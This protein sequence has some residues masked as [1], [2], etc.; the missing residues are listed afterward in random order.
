MS[1]CLCP[2]GAGSDIW[3]DRDVCPPP[4]GVMHTRCATCGEAL[5]E[6]VD[7]IAEV[8][9]DEFIASNV[10]DDSEYVGGYAYPLDEWGTRDIDPELIALIR[11]WQNQAL[12]RPDEVH[13]AWSKA[14][15]RAR[16]AARDRDA[17]RAQMKGEQ[18]AAADYRMRINKALGSTWGDMLSPDATVA[19]IE[20]LHGLIEKAESDKEKLN[21]QSDR[22]QR[23]LAQ[24]LGLAPDLAAWTAWGVLRN[25]LDELDRL[26]KHLTKVEDDKI[27]LSGE[28]ARQREEIERLRTDRDSRSG[29]PSRFGSRGFP[30]RVTLQV[31]RVKCAE[32]DEDP[33][34]GTEEVTM[35]WA[36]E[37][38]Y[39]AG[40][41]EFT[42]TPMNQYVE[43]RYLGDFKGKPQYWLLPGMD[44]ETPS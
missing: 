4:C 6:C 27:A 34:W 15:E 8:S 2:G 23:R 24:M 26:R 36:N 28:N 42:V 10:S 11:Y 3:F 17:I 39:F 32:C 20:R 25:R 5:D 12:G 44:E 21:D 19:E 18:R 40:H 13:A 41:T 30:P 35:P 33:V 16:D 1:D 7:R 31:Q 43:Y 38:R 14:D 29:S 37:H 22:Q 9:W